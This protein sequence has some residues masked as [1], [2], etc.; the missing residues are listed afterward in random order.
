MHQ[1]GGHKRN[2][3]HIIW[4]FLLFIF[5]CCCRREGEGGTARINNKN[6]R[7]WTKNWNDLMNEMW[8]RN[9]YRRINH[10]EMNAWIRFNRFLFILFNEESKKW[11]FLSL[12]KSLKRLTR[13]SSLGSFSPA[14]TERHK[15]W[16]NSWMKW[17]KKKKS[18]EEGKWCKK[19]FFGSLKVAV[20]NDPVANDSAMENV[21]QFY[22]N[23]L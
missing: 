12:S 19:I 18:K 1:L 13:V 20:R 6:N 15:K 21:I 4:I 3:A 10:Q 2:T 16:G 5:R 8:G 9:R 11:L 7:K 23:Y 14:M 22:I 17:Q